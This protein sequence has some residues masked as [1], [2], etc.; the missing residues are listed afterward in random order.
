[1][2]I[3]N[4]S[5][6]GNSVMSR[7]RWL[8]LS[9]GAFAATCMSACGPVSGGRDVTPVVETQRVVLKNLAAP[10]KMAQISDIHFKREKSEQ[11]RLAA[12]IAETGAEFLVMTGD[13][14]TTMEAQGALREFCEELEIPAYAVP[15]NWEHS[16][17]WSA[18]A[19]RKFYSGCG[20]HPL[21]NVNS[22]LDFG[23]G[24]N[25]VG[26]DD[27]FKGADDLDTALKGTDRKL[28]TLLLAHAPVIAT[29]ARISHRIDLVMC[30]HTHGGQIRFPLLGPMFM[31]PGSVGYDMGMYEIGEMR[32][33]VNRG[34]GTSF[35][36]LR[37]M[38]PPEITV[39]DLVPA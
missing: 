26:V 6:T 15:G 36:P 33:Y 5:Q 1:M 31:P 25:L 30:G 18:D 13:A 14:L 23:G 21:I 7:R 3:R 16:L 9:A 11:P 37:V 38:C 2:S 19:Q 34:I 20:I 8:G 24:I 28:P 22:R 35:M 32:L 27:P 12:Q 10:C 29:Q 39:F 4:L 17:K